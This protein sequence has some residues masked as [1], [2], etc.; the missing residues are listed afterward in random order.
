MTKR[1]L[2]LVLTTVLTFSLAGCGSTNQE[3]VS[4]DVEQQVENTDNGPV[5]LTVWGAPEESTMLKK[6]VDSFIKEYEGQ[7]QFD[8]KVEAVKEEECKDAVLEN[9]AE[10]ADVFAF[11]NKQLAPLVAAGALSAVQVPD[12][13]EIEVSAKAFERASFEKT[14]YA[15]PMATD[16]GYV[17]Y[18]NKA[19]MT[20]AEAGGS[21]DTLTYK[22]KA[23]EKKIAL[24][25]SDAELLCHFW[26]YG[27]MY[28][29]VNEEG[30]GNE[31]NFDK[32]AGMYHTD[33]MIQGLIDMD[34]TGTIIDLD[35]EETLE[36]VKNEEVIA[37]IA[38]VAFKEEV[39]K[40]LGEN[41]GIAKF[42]QFIIKNG[43]TK[44][45]TSLDYRMFGVNACSKHIDW[46]HKLARYLTTEENQLMR[47]KETGARPCNAK[48]ASSTLAVSDPVI[49]AINAEEKSSFVM[50]A[51]PGYEVAVTSFVKWFM[52]Q[53]FPPFEDVTDE[54]TGKVVLDALDR[55]H[56]FAP[57]LADWKAAIENGQAYEP[58]VKGV[59][60]DVQE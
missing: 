52:A 1:A 12:M 47:L 29:R 27:E 39:E 23:L 35:Y 5:E 19:L 38:P 60:A 32:M 9:M 7:A 58:E 37:F 56:K 26:S 41:C 4:A 48:A 30:T 55:I 43:T 13:V 51:L 57:Y 21:T 42:P 59:I 45:G 54:E 3:Q 16:G 17:V 53:D 31:T 34:Y 25:M 22:A 11:R 24:N 2:A 6:Q 18:Y 8:I 14:L 40:V 44:P 33:A 46:A 28:V 50:D 10:A 36:A 20:A 15:Y 49:K